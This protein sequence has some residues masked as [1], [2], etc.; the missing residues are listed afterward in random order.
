MK[1]I[2]LALAALLTFSGAAHAGGIF[3]KEDPDFGKPISQRQCQA[4]ARKHVEPYLRNPSAAK[5]QWGTCEAQTMKGYPLQQI[6]RQS[7]YG[8]H[9]RVNSTNKWGKYTG[10]TD[11]VIL[12]ND[13]QVIRRMRETDRGAMKKY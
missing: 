7:G 3:S 8:M 11:Y 9:F 5:Y 13:G 4:L 12:I 6:G 2:S 10:Y 1:S